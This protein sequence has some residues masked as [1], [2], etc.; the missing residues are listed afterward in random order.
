MIKGVKCILRAMEPDDIPLLYEWENDVEMWNAG[1]TKRPVSRTDIEGLV[2]QADADIYQTRQ[3]RLMVCANGV[4]VGCVD[5]FDFDPFNMRGA[6]GI[7]IAKEY[8]GN[9]FATEAVSIFTDYLVS[10]LHLHQ[11]YATACSDNVS[12][13]KVFEKCGYQKAGVRRDWYRTEN[14]YADEITLQRIAQDD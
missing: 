3:M 1:D 4:T 14:G 10:V 12:S 8:R 9:G 7:M 6:I 11:T 13:L 2:L 5:L